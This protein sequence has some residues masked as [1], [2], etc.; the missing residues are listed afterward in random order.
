MKH[1]MVL[2]LL[3]GVLGL[4]GC[5]ATPTVDDGGTVGVGVRPLGSPDNPVRC[6]LLAGE[7]A[8]LERLRCPDGSVPMFHRIGSFGVG[9]HGN[10]MDGYRVRCHPDEEGVVVFMDMYHPGHVETAPVP[11]FTIVDPKRQAVDAAAD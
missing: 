6:E 5:P 2:G 1:F 3:V 7:I 11:G 8:Y 4:P 10:I 9:P